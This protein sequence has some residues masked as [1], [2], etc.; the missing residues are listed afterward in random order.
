MRLTDAEAQRFW[1]VYDQFTAE[2]SKINDTKIALIKEYALNY[3]AITDEQA[4]QY[5]QA[6]ATAENA[7]M[8]DPIRYADSRGEGNT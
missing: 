8:M 5:L 7:A 6:R 4:D 2:L 1:P 3:G